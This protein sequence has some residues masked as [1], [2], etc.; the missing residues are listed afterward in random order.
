MPNAILDDRQKP[1]I[2]RA[3][4]TLPIAQCVS[5]AAIGDL[6]ALF[7]AKVIPKLYADDLK[8]YASLSCPSSVADFQKKPRLTY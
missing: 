1:A 6:V 8:L 2:R 7:N 5:A 4:C 3:Q